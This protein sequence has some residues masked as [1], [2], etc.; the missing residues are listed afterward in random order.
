MA[1]FLWFGGC[2]RVNL[3]EFTRSFVKDFFGFVWSLLEAKLFRG[4]D[5]ALVVLAA[6]SPGGVCC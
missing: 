3:I 1:C 2:K 6:S 4:V 5:S